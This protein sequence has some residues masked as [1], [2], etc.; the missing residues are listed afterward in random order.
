VAP[1]NA[2]K[3]L[4]PPL[5]E[6]PDGYRDSKIAFCSKVKGTELL[7]IPEVSHTREKLT[8]RTLI[9][10]VAHFADHLV[11]LLAGKVELPNLQ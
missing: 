4:V 11:T 5:V 10:G 3:I 1:A 9:S 6:P 2:I 7:E 8:E